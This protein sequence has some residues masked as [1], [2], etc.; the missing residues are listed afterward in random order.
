MTEIFVRFGELSLKS[1]TV[2]RYMESRLASNIQIFLKKM[3]YS[4][5]KV[6]INRHWG[7][8]IIN[9]DDD[10][11]DEI[12]S[13]QAME[14]SSL[15]SKNIFGITSVSPVIRT[16]SRIEDIKRIALMLAE[17]NIEPNFSFVVRAKRVGKHDYTSIELERLIGEEI[18]EN[19][20]E[21]MN[22]SVNLTHPDY[23]LQIE[24]K[25]EFAFIFD[26]KIKAYGGLPQGTQGMIVSILRGSLEDAI[27]AFLLCKRGAITIPIVFQLED[28]ENNNSNIEQINM[29]LSKIN[30][31]QPKKVSKYFSINFK[32]I[33]DQIGY[34]RINCSICDRICIGISEKIIENRGKR[35]ITLGNDTTTIL[36]RDIEVSFYSEEIPVYY[37]LISL[38]K[39][40]I[41]HPFING[42]VSGFCLQNCPGLTNLKKKEI[43]P[44]SK[45][46][47]SKIVTN[48]NFTLVKSNKI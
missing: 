43:E 31:F 1:P 25:D 6:S 41:E 21:K 8:I 37:P 27:A 22:L 46:E 16:S 36:D 38:D 33:M 15:I 5:F 20:S 11:P 47:I 34:D 2:R 17:R 24:V 13:D 7:R 30:R 4:N 14:I 3:D 12:I 35:G 44:L 28:L 26:N 19:L 18:Y 39:E 10:T 40:Q 23:R 48:T 45:E 29:Q 42:F 9:I 32:T